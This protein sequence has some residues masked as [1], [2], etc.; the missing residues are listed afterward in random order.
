[1][2]WHRKRQIITVLFGAGIALLIA[3]AGVSVYLD[4]LSVKRN[5]ELSEIRDHTDVANRL[6]VRASVRQREIAVRSA[7][8]AG[9][10]RLA[11]G[12]WLKAWCW[13]APVARSV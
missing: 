6:L 1:M 11:A 8:G 9:R 2:N 7:L 3:M 12:C 4:S 5:A 10:R 13:R